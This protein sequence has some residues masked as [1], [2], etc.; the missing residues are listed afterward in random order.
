MRKSCTTDR[1]FTLIELLT[2]IAIIGVLVALLF[3]AIKSS[4]L[5]A[6]QS[7]AQTA[8]S[9][10]ATAFKSYYTEYGKWPAA[11]SI[12]ASSTIYLS[13]ELVGLLKGDDVNGLM[14][15]GFDANPFGVTYNGN[16]RHIA[17]LEFKAADLT[18]TGT[19]TNFVD[20]WKGVYRCRFNSNYNNQTPNP[21]LTYVAYVPPPASPVNTVNTGF[22]VWSDGPDGQE[23]QNGD[24]P[25][26]A[27]NK[28][29]IKSW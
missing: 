15:A 16:P 24:V 2:V 11:E 1:A 25:P 9:G 3:P 13:T 23:D 20:P 21:F 28:D 18:I 27:L 10:L 22:L 17:F 4:M 26:S 8:I 12:P 5:K 14:A 29:N 7:K 6:E 19:T